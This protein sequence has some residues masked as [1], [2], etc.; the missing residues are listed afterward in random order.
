M[1]NQRVITGAGLLAALALGAAVAAGDGVP[2]RDTM[3]TVGPGWAVIRDMA[4]ADL[5]AG[6]N[7]V[8][9]AGIPPEC[10]PSSLI[11][12]A[13]RHEVHLVA[14][15][16]PPGSP[17]GHHTAPQIRGNDLVW[18][19]PFLPAA[20][21]PSSV[22]G[23]QMICTL[24]ASAT[25]PRDIDIIQMVT[26]MSWSAVH[27]ITLR[28]DVTNR[29]AAI[30]VDLLTEVVLSNATARSLRQA[31]LRLVGA[32]TPPAPPRESGFL[33]LAADS[34]LSDLWTQPLPPANVLY[35]YRLDSRVSVDAYGS[36][37]IPYA[38]F[39]RKPGARL[40]VATADMLDLAL[41]GRQ[42]PLLEMI[43]VRNEDAV[44]GGKPLPPGRVQ[45][46]AGSTRGLRQEEAQFDHTPPRQEIRVRLGTI[47]EVTAL[48]HRVSSSDKPDGTTQET[49]AL[50]IENRLG[51]AVNVEIQERPPTPLG[52]T[53][54]RSSVPYEARGLTVTFA[55]TV[56]ANQTSEV[57]YT[58]NV[59]RF[60]Q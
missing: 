28:G 17:A 30:A 52:W 19:E 34:P 16:R 24:A 7:R 13:P 53:L 21:P 36:A 56:A 45:V 49:Y 27:R 10:D 32:A 31:N 40:F 55:Q 6:S 60:A 54:V 48:R 1:V 25:G 8:V 39:Q 14:W 37:V 44:S 9:L 51:M 47:P 41:E 42:S 15:S 26:G 29:Q 5:A 33:K 18:T 57:T 20:P 38:G 12:R 59:R 4:V 3:A 2:I 23:D 58:I 43:V 35:E 22:A 50:V 46:Y 11:V